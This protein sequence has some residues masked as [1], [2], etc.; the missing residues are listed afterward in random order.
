MRPWLISELS[1][2]LLGPR[3]GP[4]ELISS[5]PDVQYS[6]GILAPRTIERLDGGLIE[7]QILTSEKDSFEDI[8]RAFAALQ[9]DGLTDGDSDSLFAPWLDPKSKPSSF[10]ISFTCNSISEIPE[11]DIAVTYARYR[12]LGQ[13]NKFQRQPRGGI[14]GWSDLH[15]CIEQRRSRFTGNLHLKIDDIKSKTPYL[16][17]QDSDSDSDSESFLTVTMMKGVTGSEDTWTVSVMFSTNLEPRSE[18]EQYDASLNAELNIHQPEIRICLHD[19][20]TIVEN[21]VQ[22]GDAEDQIDALLYSGRGQ[23]ARGHLCSAIWKEFDPQNIPL[24]NLDSMINEEEIE[25][26]ILESPPFAW[27]DRHHPNIKQDSIRFYPPDVRSEYLPMLNIPAPIM[28]PSWDIE[29]ELFASKL[30]EASSSSEIQSLLNPLVQ[31]YENWISNSFD[32]TQP[33]HVQLEA[34]AREALQRMEKGVEL[35]IND[36]QARLA[37]NIANKAIEVNCQ[38]NTDPPQSLRWRKFQLSFALSVLESTTNRDSIDRENLDLLWVATGGGKTEAYL[39]V[40]AYILALRRLRSDGTHGWQGV[41]VLTRYTLRLLTIQQFRRALGVITALEYLRV[42]ENGQGWLP[43]GFEHTHVAEGPLLGNQSFGIGIWVGGSVTPNRLY[44]G[45]GLIDNGNLVNSIGQEIRGEFYDVTRM[46]AIKSLIAGHRLVDSRAKRAAEPA[47]LL[48]CPA[49]DCVLSYS[50]LSGNTVKET[51]GTIHWVIETDAVISDIEDEIIDTCDEVVDIS[52][53]RHAGNFYTISLELNISN[54]IHEHSVETLADNIRNLARTMGVTLNFCSSRAS[55]PGYFLRS[56]LMRG[57][58]RRIHDFEIRCPSPNCGLNQVKWKANSPAGANIGR[59]LSTERPALTREGH[60]VEVI[61]CWRVDLDDATTARGIPIPAYT[62]DDQIYRSL[63]SLIISTVDK[64][65]RI[66]F[67]PR[68]SGLFGNVNHHHEING[69][70]RAGSG[71]NQPNQ[72]ENTQARIVEI[73]ECLESPELIIQDELHLIEGPLGSMVG[74]YETVVEELIREGLPN[75]SRPKYIASTATIRSAEPQ[76]RCL[77]DRGLNLFP[78]KGPNWKDRG[79]ICE[80]DKEDAHDSGDGPG[81]LYLGMCPIGASGLGLQRDVYSNLLHNGSRL[82]G[83]RYWTFVAYYNAVRELAGGRALMEQDVGL[84]LSRL[85]NRDGVERGSNTIVELSGRM[86]SSD[87]PILLNQLEAGER[88]HGNSVDS[89]LTTSMF[90]T[91]VDVNRLNLM[92]V[93][94]QPKTTAQYIQA[95]GRVGRRNG[96][97]VSVYLQGGRPRDLDHY[98]RFLSYHLQLHR[99]VEPVTV[100]PFSFPVLDRAAGPLSVAWMRT[101]R[102]CTTHPWRTKGGASSHASGGIRPAEFDRFIEIIEARNLAQ[103]PERRIVARP[104]N[105]IQTNLNSG[106]DRWG[107]ISDASNLDPDRN[108]KWVDY[109]N[110][111]FGPPPEHS[112]V[113]LGD[114]RHVKHPSDHRAAYSP[115]YP[116]PTSLRTV[117]SQVGVQTRRGV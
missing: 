46:P 90:G 42:G 36:D 96:A 88:G 44:D 56:H 111:G 58:R 24:D 72:I 53:T 100:R 75:R 50:R 98:E 117:D 22:T 83:D 59:S 69:F 62:V 23:R 76:V 92:F 115:M 49:C 3:D 93:A 26:K 21:I 39:L 68:T 16:I 85:S 29:P 60:A 9:D 91:G 105:A 78:P 106:W 5:R 55:R 57:D 73:S 38:W 20:T 4:T 89:L 65:A 80:N 2:D 1:R 86:V 11:F 54:G 77:F 87:L 82:K 35:L 19:S 34:K 17:P 84:A 81:R 108:M 66:P 116:A 97:L 14:I 107:V 32:L 7:N 13:E 110:S 70:L 31:G 30:S 52:S 112:D 64:F 10:G 37:F 63:P 25:S 99:Y 94:G 71:Q 51:S 104:P 28:D 18:E 43:E 47:Q 27:V 40:T 6:I 74:F 67:E 41:N 109:A 61:D 101:S 45:N 8:F 113:V 48:H 103:T 95:T 12:Y 33:H 114:E 15:K 79:L 102:L